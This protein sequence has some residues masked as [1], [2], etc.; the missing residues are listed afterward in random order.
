MWFCC[1]ED[2][3]YAEITWI[4]VNFGV[5]IW[6]YM[7]CVLI[8]EIL[9]GNLC[10]KLEYH[11]LGSWENTR[12]VMELE[13]WVFDGLTFCFGLKMEDFRLSMLDLLRFEQKKMWFFCLEDMNCAGFTWIKVKSCFTI[14]MCSFWQRITMMLGNSWNVDWKSLF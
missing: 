7:L 1:L 10:F 12:K 3:N 11:V 9:I 2:M 4:K 8:F 13:F 5:T 6:M 14:W